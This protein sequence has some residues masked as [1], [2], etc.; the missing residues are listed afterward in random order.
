MTMRL[1]V[2]YAV[3]GVYSL[4]FLYFAYS[5]VRFAVVGRRIEASRTNALTVSAFVAVIASV[6]LWF[7]A[8]HRFVNDPN[9]YFKERLVMRT[10]VALCVIA[11]LLARFAARRTSIPVIVGALLVALNWI[12]SII[13]D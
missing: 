13:R 10:G 5:L 8:L 2:G 1:L 11:I 6:A 7:W 3:W 12:G 4:F 9:W